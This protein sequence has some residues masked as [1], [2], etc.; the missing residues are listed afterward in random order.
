MGITIPHDPELENTLCR[1]G[2]KMICPHGD[3]IHGKSRK[4]R[5]YSQSA[6]ADVYGKLRDLRRQ[7]A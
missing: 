3:N 7:V 2:L 4:K 6:R 1:R 5:G